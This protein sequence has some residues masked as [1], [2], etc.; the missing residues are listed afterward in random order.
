MADYEAE[1]AHKFYLD[2]YPSPAQQA[3]FCEAYLA[4]ADPTFPLADRHER[5]RRAAALAA[6]ANVFALASHLLWSL[7]GLIQAANSNIDFDYLEY[8]AQRVSEYFRHRD[9]Y[10][11]ALSASRGQPTKR[12][13][14]KRA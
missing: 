3:A 14:G 8:S 12:I 5:H 4:V 7:W 6:E 9:R 10:L 13:R 2:R 1:P 11:A